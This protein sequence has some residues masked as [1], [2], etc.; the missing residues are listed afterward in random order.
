MSDRA[1]FCLNMLDL[2]TKIKAWVWL[3][4]CQILYFKFILSLF[5]VNIYQKIISSI[6]K[7]DNKQIK[8]LSFAASVQP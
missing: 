7:K 4:I 8:N 1:E 6:S 5:Y 3:I 2:F